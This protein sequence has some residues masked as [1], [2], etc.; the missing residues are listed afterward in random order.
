MIKKAAT[1]ASIDS[2]WIA[3]WL[4]ACVTATAV[5]TDATVT[6]MLGAGLSGLVAGW[7]LSFTMTYRRLRH[8]TVC[9]ED[10]EVS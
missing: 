2:F 5:F 4:M 1:T 10:K 6:E 9:T 7:G 8:A 3:L